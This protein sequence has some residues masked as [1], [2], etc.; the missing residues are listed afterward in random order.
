MTGLTRRE[1]MAAGL[2]AAA[3]PA[4]ASAATQPIEHLLDTHDAL[5]LAALVKARKVSPTELLDAADRPGRSAQSA[6]QLH[7]AETL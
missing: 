3:L 2:A 6:L 4:A 1:T 5:A 7:G